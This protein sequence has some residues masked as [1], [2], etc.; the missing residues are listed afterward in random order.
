MEMER[1]NMKHLS[2]KEA[3]LGLFLLTYV[4]SGVFALESGTTAQYIKGNPPV[5]KANNNESTSEH[6]V[7]ITV[8]T[9]AAGNTVIGNRAA[10]VGDYIV[11]TYTVVD[12]DGDQ[13][14]GAIKEQLKVFYK[15]ISENKWVD[16]TSKITKE[17]PAEGNRISFKITDDFA[18]VSKIGFQLLE[19]TK[20][21][22]PN[23]NKWLLT[24][25]IWS[26]NGP[27][28]VNNDEENDSNNPKN[29]G[30]DNGNAPYGPGVV[31]AGSGNGPIESNNLNIGIF[32]Y[33]KATSTI[34]RTINY[35]ESTS[36]VVP[37]YGDTFKVVVWI[38]KDQ[39]ISKKF[40]ANDVD[41]TTSYQY[42][43]TL[44]GTYEQ[45]KAIEDN[46]LPGTSS[47]VH[48]IENKIRDIITLGSTKDDVKHNSMYPSSYLAGAQGYNLVVSTT[49]RN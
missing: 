4:P 47:S 6:T 45:I 29:P 23:T 26:T 46:E 44:S 12:A 3:A 8:S 9:D 34:D 36:Q 31:T 15:D 38:D 14:L 24:T 18:G 11:L 17:T 41:I 30:E 40:D 7:T 25:D 43:W 10:K 13:D 20:Y 49:T 42:K 33:N 1:L 22:V 19:S 2:I 21:G 27:N 16:V 39:G 37:K 35:A 28:V 5:L 32:K 48:P